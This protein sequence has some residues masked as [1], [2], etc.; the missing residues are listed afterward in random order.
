M[1]SAA[2]VGKKA[3]KIEMAVQHAETLAER[4]RTRVAEAEALCHIRRIG[5]AIQRG[6]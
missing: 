6:D 2:T 1:P 4:E 5:D 3:E